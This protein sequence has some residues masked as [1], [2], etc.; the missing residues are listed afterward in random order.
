MSYTLYDIYSMSYTLCQIY[1]NPTH[2]FTHNVTLYMSYT[3][4]VI[5]RV[6]KI[7]LLE[8]FLCKSCRIYIHS[9]HVTCHTHKTCHIHKTYYTYNIL[10]VYDYMCVEYYIFEQNQP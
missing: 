4:Y 5:R 10:Y 9:T 1:V 7:F 2:F 3:L 8:I 6:Y